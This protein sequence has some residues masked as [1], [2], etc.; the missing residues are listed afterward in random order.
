MLLCYVQWYTCMYW[1]VVCINSA[2]CQLKKITI[3]VRLLALRA[4]GATGDY[5]IV[6]SRSGYIGTCQ[7]GTQGWRPT[8]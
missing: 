1:Y 5:P 3:T 4:V 8:E 6:D 2:F 7:Q